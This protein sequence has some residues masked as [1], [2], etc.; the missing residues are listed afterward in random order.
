MILATAFAGAALIL[1][2]IGVYGVTAFA[3]AH[4]RRELGVRL[5]IEASRRHVM[6]FVLGENA[7]LAVAGLVGAAIAAVLL[8]AQLFGVT[9]ADRVSSSRV[10]V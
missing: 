10:G 5:A 8:R 7:R 4:R 2:A 1:A 6:S 3:V 9:P